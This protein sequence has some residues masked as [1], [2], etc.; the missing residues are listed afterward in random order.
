MATPDYSLLDADILTEIGRKNTHFT[1]LVTKLETSAKA[2]CKEKKDEPFR[3][4]DRRLQALR[5][6]GKIG[7]DTKHGW[8][9]RGA[10]GSYIEHK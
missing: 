3:V 7:H 5:K 4:I 1:G 10:D 8:M 2:F 6:K 9:L